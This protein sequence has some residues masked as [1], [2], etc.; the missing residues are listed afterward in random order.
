MGMA[1]K[2]WA[3]SQ[4]FCML[5]A[6]LNLQHILRSAPAYG[7]PNA[8]ICVDF[9]EIALFATF[10]NSKFLDFVWLVVVLFPDTTPRT[11]THRVLSG[12]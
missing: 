4:K 5:H 2:K 9:A 3:G 10:A 11:G 1:H 8:L 6:Q 12:A 7:V